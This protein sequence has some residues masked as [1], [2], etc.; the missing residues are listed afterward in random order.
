[1]IA[2]AFPRMGEQHQLYAKV[3][4]GAAGKPVTFRSLD[5]GGDKVLP[6]LSRLVHEENPAMGWRAIRLG[7]DRPA[8]L[9]TQIR[10]LL[11][12]A[13]GRE[14]RLMFPMVSEVMEFRRAKTLVE[15][16]QR[17]LAGHGYTPPTAVRLGAM[18]E[19]PALLFEL[20]ELLN[21]ADFVSV[22]SNDLF[23][24]MF[25]ADRGNGLMTERFDPLSPSFLRALR[26]IARKAAQAG[27]PAT[28]CGELA[29]KPLSAMALI[30]V[31]FRSISMAP[32]SVGPVKAMIRAVD[33]ALLEG[34]IDKA[35]AAPAEGSLRSILEAFA[36]D[37]DVPLT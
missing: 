28:L 18:V 30:G 7:L 11:K 3:L 5:I 34:V 26:T 4:D 27:R 8:L 10:A 15:R 22:G 23:Q 19:V 2:S 25:A 9:R 14:L 24:F 6:Y 21:E 1:M 33:V 20:D 36:S 17:F 29:G 37:H 35:L 32:A 16:E 12:A 13:Q 31:G